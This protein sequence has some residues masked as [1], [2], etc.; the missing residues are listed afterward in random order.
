MATKINP[1]PAL[2][3]R[4]DTVLSEC[5]KIMNDHHIGSIL[6]VSDQG[7]ADLVGIFTERDLLVKFSRIVEKQL[8]DQPIREV[9]TTPVATLDVS[10]LDQA[11][12]FMLARNFR[13]VPV[14][15]S[16]IS[17][18]RQVL[19]GI[20]SMRD[21]FKSFI[22]ESQGKTS[23]L[24]RGAPGAASGRVRTDEKTI[25]IFSRDQNFATFL[26]KMLNDFDLG[27]VNSLDFSKAVTLKADVLII[28]L[29]GLEISI[30]T[31]YLKKLNQDPTVKAAVIVFDPQRQAP[32]VSGVL[33]QLGNSGKFTIFRKPI[34][35][36]S[37]FERVHEL[38]LADSLK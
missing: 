29:D 27:Q 15:L 4:S 5:I 18:S 26:K 9:M 2:I 1:S 12:E 33:E 8:W 10:Q 37:F 28:D 17:Q 25:N 22:K 35:I 14:T 11:A 21:L 30:W 16:D 6:V 20:I 13:H 36:L 23:W 24:N 38:S 34:D 3:T 7:Q 31:Q 32:E 19:A